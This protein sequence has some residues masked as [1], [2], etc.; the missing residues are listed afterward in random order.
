LVGEIELD[1]TF[2]KTPSDFREWLNTNHATARELWVGFYKKSTNLPSIS[3]PEA[4]DQALCFGW[5]DGIRKSLDET[6]YVIRFTPRNPKSIWSSVNTK[7][8]GELTALGLM[9]PS[10]LV[11][12]NQRDQQKSE[13]YSYEQ[14]ENAR[15]DE[16]YAQQF[17]A[18]QKAWDFFTAQPP[19]YQKAAIWWVISAKKE[20]TRLKRLTTLITDSENTRPIA[21]FARPTKANSQKIS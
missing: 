14:R 7:R 15:L 2:F 8:V 21:A 12:F 18:N 17:Q 4:V 10:G 3:W 16:A 19:S 6:S 1:A 20:E 13:L 5:I 11:I 9:Q